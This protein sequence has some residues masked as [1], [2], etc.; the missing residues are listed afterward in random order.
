MR[1]AHR[2]GKLMRCTAVD[3]ASHNGAHNKLRRG[4]LPQALGRNWFCHT[5]PTKVALTG[6]VFAPANGH[7]TSSAFFCG[8]KRVP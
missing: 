7:D 5:I 8:R 2:H 4:A 3:C 6:G 1:F